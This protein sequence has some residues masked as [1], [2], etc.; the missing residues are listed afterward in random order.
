MEKLHN[1]EILCPLFIVLLPLQL[2]S[3]LPLSSAYTAPDEYFINCGS[4]SNFTGSGSRNFVGDLNSG[5]S[6]LVGQSSPVSDAS[7]SAGISPLYESA[8]IYRQPS[9]YE[10]AINQNGTYFVRLH[11]FGSSSSNYLANAIF[12]VSASGF[13]LLS[14][15][16]VKN[17]SGLPV[18]KEFLVTIN[19]GRFK[20]NFIPSGGSHLAF[21]NAIEVFLAPESFILDSAPHV[22]PTGS[23]NSFDG[24]TSLV[25]HTLYRINVGGL[26]LTPENDTLWRNWIP[27][28]N[29][30]FN[31]KAARNSEFFTDTPKYQA[32]GATEYT[33]PSLVYKTA[34]ELNID[35]SR[36]S[37][38]FNITWSFSVSKSSKH[39]VRVHFCDIISVSLDVIIF[40][41]YIYDKFGQRI[42]PYDKMGQLAA[43]FYFDF[44]VD[45]DESGIMNI[46]VGPRHDSQNPTAFLNGLE[47]MDFVKKSEFDSFPEKPRSRKTSLS[48]IVGSIV[49]VAIVFVLIVAALLSWKCRKAKP[50]QSSSW[51]L[52][53]PLYG[54]GSSYNRMSDKASNMSPSNLNLALRISYYE[55]EQSTKNFD[56]NLLIGE[57]GFG[58][59]YEGMFRGTKVAVKRSEPGHGQGLLEFQTEIVVLSQ[60]RHRHLVSLIGFCEERSE[61]ILVYEFMEKGTLRDNLYYSTANLEKSYSARN[62]LS[63]KQRLEICIGAAKGLNYLHTGSSGGIIHRDVKSTNILL[64]EQFVAKVADF[65]LSKSG[66]PDVEHS[67]DVKGTFGYLDPEY[68]I[69]LQLTDKS[70]VYSFGVVLLEA[71]CARPAVINSNRREE[72]N[73]AEWGMLWLRK[74]ELEKIIDPMLVDTINPNSLRKFAEITEK[75]LKPSGSERP[76]M[77]DV[78]WDL[79]YALQLQ[80]T[81]LSRGPLEDS[82]T[83]ASLEFSMPV[84]NRLPSNSCPTVD[85]ED[86][87]VLFDNDSVVTASEV[88]SKLRIGEAR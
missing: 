63:W 66:L 21:V 47:I 15:F 60:I 38:F 1:L 25:L 8:R 34:K 31:P 39:F 46:S 17:N 68:F 59:V 13:W 49:G 75:C 73:L 57:G 67:V 81:P 64:D 78:L 83:N 85:E 72:V 36:Q 3:L 12:N 45:S 79:E 43:P 55:I 6:F 7:S 80:L 11:F 2:F 62:E 14:N 74:G 22:A 26:T 50:E 76:I 10:F 19:L 56:S 70:D 42:S 82:T 29:F 27:D 58:K 18:I 23:R 20:I 71:L 9:F 86:A 61:M 69:S 40:N 48:A 33:A 35:D 44:V 4:R 24:L 88:F 53:L 32:G 52:S 84:I 87:T 51:P 5:V 54:R 41:L 28:D 16:S 37:N 65:G 77:R 30:L